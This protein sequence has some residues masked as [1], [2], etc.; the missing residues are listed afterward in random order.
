MDN[1]Y[2]IYGFEHDTWIL[3][4]ICMYMCYSVIHWVC[5]L[6]LAKKFSQA[7]IV[8]YGILRALYSE[9]PADVADFL[10]LSTFAL[11]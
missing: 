7:V 3:Y 5:G 9:R 8:V 11:S 10:I 6:F 2:M 1:S 4:D